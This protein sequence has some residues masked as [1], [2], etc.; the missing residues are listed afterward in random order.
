MDLRLRINE[1]F[2]L[3]Q[4]D[5]DQLI[6]DLTEF[7]FDRNVSTRNSNEFEVSIGQIIFNFQL[8]HQFA[9]KSEAYHRAEI[10]KKLIIIFDNIREK[11]LEEIGGEE[12]GL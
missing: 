6:A 3:N 8:E 9:V 1:Y 11:F 5:R 7:Y 10:Y 2:S 4:K 12:Y